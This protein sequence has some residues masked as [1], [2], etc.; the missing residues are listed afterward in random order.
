[1]SLTNKVAYN[2]II[3]F[4]G[5]IITT[6][7]SLILIAALTR[8][9]G[10]AGFGDYTTI[11][12]FVAFAAILADF[13]FF[14]IMLREISKDAKNT[15]KIVNNTM[16]M[17]GILG[18]LV[19]TLA[20][21]VSLYIGEYSYD[22]RLGIAV[23]GF[24]WFWTTVNST[25]VGLFQAKLDMSKSAIAEV[26]GRI[27]TF[28][29]VMLFIKL[30][31]SL[32]MILSAYVIGNFV[33]FAVSVIFGHKYINFHLAFDFKFWKK[34]FIEALPMGIALILGLIYFRIDTVMLSIMRSNIDVGIYGAP[35]KILEVLQ[36]VPVIF[37]GNVF[38]IITNYIANKDKRLQSTIQ[39]SFDFLVILACPIIAGGIILATPII[40]F[41]AGSEFVS[42]S[43]IGSVFGV[44]ATAP[45]VLQI[46]I[47]AVGTSF[48]SIKY[49]NIVIALGKQKELA[50]SY[51]VL[52]LVN[53]GLNLLVIPKYSYMGAASSTLITETL[54]L[55]L[56]ARIVYKYMKFKINLIVMLKAISASIV[57]AIGLYF[58]SGVNLF[59][60]MIIGISI[61]TIVLY[62]IGG[63]KKEDIKKIINKT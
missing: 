37:L 4:V 14:W 2:T 52:V 16:T 56:T 53:I 7:L 60:G 23:V 33:N 31:F 48:V 12:S 8:Y 6:F 58:L 26:I 25:Y 49:T 34:M 42:A 45:H 9:L 21:I 55:L 17:R 5:K 24:A 57:M 11:F 38:P 50:W 29:I 59:I 22:I 36:L 1:M 54:V 18:L 43:T 35:Y 32:F 51:L 61:Y 47:I 15:E 10:V 28:L 63:I 39:K 19:F 46:L 27:A 40:G 30:E 62:F 3:Q 20:Y 44:A 41:I 13:G